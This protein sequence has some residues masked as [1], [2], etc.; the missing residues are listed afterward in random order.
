M[1]QY[2]TLLQYNSDIRMKRNNAF[3]EIRNFLFSNI[4]KFMRQKY[5]GSSLTIKQLLLK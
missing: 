4:S 5:F 2:D 3:C 1:R